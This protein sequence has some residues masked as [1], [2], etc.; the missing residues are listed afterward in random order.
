MALTRIA[1]PLLEPI[2]L[3]DMRAH[4]RITSVDA[5]VDTYISDCI[6]AA[7]GMLDAEGELGLCLIDQDWAETFA[8]GPR[9]GRD[10]CLSL[11]PVSA[12]VSVEYRDAAGDWVT[13]PPADFA[14]YTN[15]ETGGQFVRSAAWPPLA[16]FPDALKVTY[17]AGMSPTPAGVPAPLRHALKILAA[18]FF[19]IREAVV[20]GTVASAIP[21]SVDRLI[22]PY[23]I[24]LK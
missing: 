6:A 10:L 23:R 22:A 7:V 16:P 14:L 12:I 17:R 13:A 3:A 15:G 1:P 11:G 18:H 2:D 4:L 21:I 5:E 24:Y 8:S 19:E 9:D 20:I